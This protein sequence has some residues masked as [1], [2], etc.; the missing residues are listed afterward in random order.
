MHNRARFLPIHTLRLAAWK[1]EIR[2]EEL[3]NKRI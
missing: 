1:R 3:T 2:C